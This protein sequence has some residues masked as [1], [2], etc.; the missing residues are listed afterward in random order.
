MQ[1]DWTPISVYLVKDPGKS[2][3]ESRGL[4]LATG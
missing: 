1:K 2:G 3:A 4:K